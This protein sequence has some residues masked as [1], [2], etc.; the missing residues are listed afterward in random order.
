MRIRSAAIIEIDG[1][2][3]LMKRIRNNQEYY[4]FPGGGMEPGETPEEAAIREI[5]EEL[6][7][8][9]EIEKLI[10]TVSFNSLQYY[11]KGKYIKGEFGTGVGEE[12]HQA[13]QDR[14]IY[15]PELIEKDHLQYLDIRPKEILPLI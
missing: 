4:V 1:K 3:A 14:G 15:I 10:T 7:I 2:I 8:D 5:K 9:I 13:D 11:F 6:G 12:F